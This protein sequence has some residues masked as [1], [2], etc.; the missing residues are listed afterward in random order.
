MEPISLILGAL[1]AVK[2]TIGDQVIKDGY[3][4]L[5]QLLAHKFG[6][7]NPKLE[8]RIEEYVED[9][10]TYAKPAEKALRDA[11]ADRDEEVRSAAAE[12]LTKAEA[13]KPG[14]SGG[15]IGQLNATNSNVAVANTMG[16]VTFGSL[17]TGE[18]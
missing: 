9:P 12:L 13:S 11:G 3:Q 1:A 7:S 16:N 2:Q 17:P 14:V 6:G 4:G 15:L 5:K 8:Q 18:K 10:E